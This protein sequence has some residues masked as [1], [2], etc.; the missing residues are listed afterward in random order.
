VL[1]STAVFIA[2][3]VNVAAFFAVQPLIDVATD[4]AGS[5]PL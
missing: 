5:L 3:V 4:A 1:L 2:M